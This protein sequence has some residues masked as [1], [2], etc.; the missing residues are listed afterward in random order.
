M[1]HLYIKYFNACIK[2]SMLH[3]CIYILYYCAKQNYYSSYT[4]TDVIWPIVIWRHHWP[5]FMTSHNAYLCILGAAA[6][7]LHLMILNINN[8]T[9]FYEN[10]ARPE[11]MYAIKLFKPSLSWH[12][13]GLKV[14]WKLL[15]FRNLKVA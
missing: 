7:S 6:M 10:I 14:H 11:L 1:C 5:S 2:W 3:V 8:F 4:D 9:M 13:C 15:K 12:E